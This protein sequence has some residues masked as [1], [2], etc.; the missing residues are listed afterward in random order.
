M[1]CFHVFQSYIWGPLF[2]ALGAG[3]L[4]GRII[5]EFND[6]YIKENNVVDEVARSPIKLFVLF[7]FPMFPIVLGKA[8]SSVPTIAMAKDLKRPKIGAQL[9]VLGH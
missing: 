6:V 9:I 1:S 4:I 8:L 7:L 2:L 5:Q 3:E